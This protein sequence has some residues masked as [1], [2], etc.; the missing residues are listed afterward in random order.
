[1]KEYLIKKLF[2][3]VLAL[4]LG[5]TSLLA[6]RVIN[7]S[8]KDG[9][10]NEPLIGATVQIKG[11]SSGTVTDFD[12]NYQ[13]SVQ[14]DTETLIFGYVGF[15]PQEFVVGSQTQ[16]NVD[17]IEDVK[18]LTE[19]V[20]VGYAS[21]KKVDLTGSVSVVSSDDL[22]KTNASRV[23]KA[24]QGKAAG[25]IISQT[26]G[27]PGQGMNVRIRG[28]GSI[29]KDA[30]PLYIIDGLQG[31]GDLLN[32]INPSDIESVS[33]LK[34][35]SA[36]AIYGA[37]AAN[38]VILIKTKRGGSGKPSISFSAYKG[39]T[40]LHKKFDVMNSD[41]YIKFL[42]SSYSQSAKM[43]DYL[44]KNATATQIRDTW[45]NMAA[46]RDTTR[47]KYGDISTDWQDEISRMGDV[48]NY[49]LSI[50]GGT[51]KASYTVSGNYN[52][53]NGILIGNS[54]ERFS[55]RAAGDFTVNNWFKIGSSLSFSHLEDDYYEGNMWVTSTITSPLMP[56]YES[57]NIGGYAGPT[58]TLTGTKNERTNPVAEIR[59]N[60]SNSI[61]NRVLSSINSEIQF[62]KG[63]KYRMDFSM[64]YNLS[65]GQ[66]WSPKYELGSLGNRSNPKSNLRRSHGDNRKFIL[67]NTLNYNTSLGGFNGGLMAGHEINMG[68]Y[69]SFSASGNDF[70]NPKYNVLSQAQMP[71][72]VDGYRGESRIESLF[73]RFNLD[74]RSKYLITATLRRDGS[75]NFGPENRY[76]VFPSF[77]A[78]WKFNEDF[79]KGVKQIDML[80]FRFGYGETGNQDIGSFNYLDTM[81]PPKNSQ[82]VFGVNQDP[83]YGG[84][85]LASA[86]ANK[87]I[88]WEASRMYNF[89]LDVYGFG[90]RIEF[91]AEYYIRK[92]DE[93]LV[94]IPLSTIYG[95]LDGIGDPWVN[96]GEITNRG[97]D[98]NLIYRKREGVF[99]YTISGNLQTISN[100][101]DYLP[102]DAVYAGQ[103]VTDVGHTIGSFYGYVAEGIFQSWDEVNA[104]AYQE[105]ATAPG[106]IKFSDL[107]KDGK[108]T[109]DDQTII[110]KNLPDLTYSLDLSANWKGFDF[111]VFFYGVE[112]S[113][114]YNQH[115]ATIGVATDADNKDNNKLVDVMNFWT[116]ENHST[117]MTRANIEDPNHNDRTSSWF[118]EDA[119]YLRLKNMQIGYSFPSNWLTKV[120]LT[121]LRV[122]VSASNLKTWTKYSGYDPEVSSTNPL[123]SG[124]DAGSYPVPKTY[125]V[126]LQ[127]NF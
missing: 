59:L 76:G 98:F 109:A 89:G 104:S 60:Q 25:V 28:I 10:T 99:N 26:S 91:T 90:N 93:L 85:V 101:V 24:L 57:K 3:A 21:T 20:V 40:V 56:I 124:I 19:I 17:L 105:V 110:G 64:D 115:R 65:S 88:K 79:L 48:Q 50:S 119:S 32:T 30:Q 102:G 95:R 38:G 83:Y 44:G 5:S 97:F 94:K 75:S 31:G 82:Y 122:Y 14:S 123:A 2:I 125:L 22:A 35:A 70:L 73:G 51:D 13:I 68:F 12:G 66:T 120:N 112:G 126:G 15:T 34:D 78:A 61:T 74:F 11:L 4:L 9:K 116:E 1:M 37:Q 55:I 39:V 42:D 54:F 111:S 84:M 49:D 47:T 87:K 92:Q 108:I 69:D 63:F 127:L 43:Q 53:E 6:Q 118:L 113:D 67:T 77:S 62:F 86:F 41:Q 80:K 23:D 7:G 96:L 71:T 46:Y 81:D 58:D 33:V 36:A 8:V 72:A 16:I 52:K 114:V 100:N 117:T 18:E 121:T 29:N 107:N 27:R 103:T 106:D 45:N